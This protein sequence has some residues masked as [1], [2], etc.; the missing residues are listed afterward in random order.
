MSFSSSFQ[1]RFLL[2]E[3]LCI[4]LNSHYCLQFLSLLLVQWSWSD[5]MDEDNRCPTDYQSLQ[6]ETGTDSSPMSFILRSKRLEM[7]S[8]S[9]SVLQG[10]RTSQ[11]VT[12][13]CKWQLASCLT[14]VYCITSGLKE[15][16]AKILI[17]SCMLPRLQG[18]F[19][20]HLWLLGVKS[21]IAV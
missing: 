18:F 21:Q 3:I 10:S 12:V 11:S 13:S 4:F 20:F 15:G 19:M 2:A 5:V 8:H 7:D 1:D 16:L 6:L 17:S 14:V 9:I